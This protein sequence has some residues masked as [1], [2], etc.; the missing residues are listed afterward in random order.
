MGVESVVGSFCY[1]LGSRGIR[2]NGLIEFRVIG[3]NLRVIMVRA[4]AAP[5]GRRPY[6]EG[7]WLGSLVG[8]NVVVVEVDSDALS[9]MASE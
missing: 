8:S 6:V 7:F 3:G 9:E 5:L 4:V 2:S 1:A